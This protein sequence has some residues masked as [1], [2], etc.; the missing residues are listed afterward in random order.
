M[1][2]QKCPI[3]NGTGKILNTLSSS[4]FTICD[5]CNGKKII[6]ELNGEP[7]I[8]T[9]TRTDINPGINGMDE[10]QSEYFGKI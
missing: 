6:S 8:Y 1:A 7:P 4:C 5:T 3:C 10:C 9:N 2:W